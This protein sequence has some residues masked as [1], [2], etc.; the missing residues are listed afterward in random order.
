MPRY[1]VEVSQP[2]TVAAKRINESV[3][4]L[5]S[6]F[7]THADWRQ[8]PDGAS[9]GSLVVEAPDRW[10]ALGV[11]PTGMRSAAQIFRVISETP[12]IVRSARSKIAAH[13]G[14]GR[15]R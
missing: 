2:A 13:D 7:A 15:A 14:Y 6:H 12:T 3:H 11:V 9:I 5:G 8:K 1:L 10:S 4:M